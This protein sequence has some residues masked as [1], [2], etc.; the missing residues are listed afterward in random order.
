[1]M[2][3]LIHIWDRS[4]PKEE[5]ENRIAAY[6]TDLDKAKA[7]EA[8]N[9]DEISK[10]ISD[11]TAYLKA[12]FDKDYYQ[13]LKESCEQEK[14][15]AK[16]KYQKKIA[17]LEKEHQS[18]LSKLTDHQEVKLS[19]IHILSIVK[20]V[21]AIEKRGDREQI[22]LESYYIEKDDLKKTHFEKILYPI[23]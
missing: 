10:L 14:V 8:K 13:P 18:N 21:E 5:K 19:L 6:K 2:L 12:H 20:A 22:K 17:E 11:A 3:S 9:K 7:V 4:I 23:E 1:M 15:L 16:E